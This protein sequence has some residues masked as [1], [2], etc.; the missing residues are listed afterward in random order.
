M[1]T[2]ETT[3]LRGCK[4]ITTVRHGKIIIIITTI[5]L[6]GKTIIIIAHPQDNKAMVILPILP[7]MDK[8]QYHGVSNVILT[9]GLMAT[10]LMKEKTVCVNS[11]VIKMEPPLKIKWVA[12]QETANGSV[13]N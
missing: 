9:A 5:V 7:I 11:K 6:L 12:I 2:E 4:I 10:A 13:S 8:V 1:A 3:I